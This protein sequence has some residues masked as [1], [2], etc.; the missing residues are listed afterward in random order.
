VAGWQAARGIA[1]LAR[2]RMT[3]LSLSRRR[4]L[5]T[6]AVLAAI[7]AAFI[8]WQ[9]RRQEHPRIRFERLTL[10]RGACLGP[11]PVYKVTV[12]RNGHV[13]YRATDFHRDPNGKFI[14]ATI[15]KQGEMPASSLHALIAAVESSDY[16]A[17]DENYSLSVTDLPS[18]DIQVTGGGFATRTHVYAVPCKKDAKGDS[19]YQ[20][21][22]SQSPPVPD[23]FCIVEEIVDVGSCAR[24]WGQDARPLMMG[25]IPTLQTPP[26]CKVAP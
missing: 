3:A 2:R 20:D 22:K 12:E 7:A 5:A 23:I 24:Y 25:D 13:T 10:D 18:T 11:C 21:M 15:L 1:S 8:F 9:Q 6:S 14:G 16:A 4:I 17:L 26:R 19:M